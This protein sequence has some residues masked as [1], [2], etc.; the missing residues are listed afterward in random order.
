MEQ[1]VFELKDGTKKWFINGKF[2]D[3]N[4]D[5]TMTQTDDII[6]I[7]DG[8]GT[9]R[10]RK[11]GKLHRTDGPAVEFASG[12]KE[13]YFEGKEHRTDGPAVECANGTKEWWF[14]GKRHRTDGP[15]IEWACGKKEWWFE[16]VCYDVHEFYMKISELSKK[17]C[18]EHCIHYLV[19]SFK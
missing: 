2:V 19:Q 18:C 9:K 1:T 13:W 4:K 12:H 10:Y 5:E 7:V 3:E 17:K 16:G 6:Y 11:H 8:V 15:A 14:E